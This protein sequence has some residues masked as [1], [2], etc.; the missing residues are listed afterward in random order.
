[1]V[2]QGDRRDIPHPA[3][4]D[5]AFPILGRFQCVG[6]LQLPGR[7]R[8]GAE[9]FLHEVQRLGLLE[10]TRN[11]QDDIVR[12]VKLLVEGP[13][14]FHRNLL[15]VTPVADRGLAVVVP[16]VCGGGQPLAK[17]PGRGIFTALKL[18]ADDG[19]LR[20]QILLLDEAVHE[21]VGLEIKGEFQIFI[22]RHQRLVIIHPVA[23]RASVELGAML[24]KR[25]GNVRMPGCSLEDHVLQQVRHAGLAIPLLPGAHQH[26]HVHRHLGLRLVR[27]QQ[28]PQTVVELVF[29]DPLHRSDFAG[30]LRTMAEL[31]Q[32]GKGHSNGQT[33]KLHDPRFGPQPAKFKPFPNFVR[34]GIVRAKNRNRR[35]GES[36]PLA[37]VPL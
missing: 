3:Q 19:H 13:E 18:V 25:L 36:K 22:G 9:I 4:G 26:R 31:K 6:G 7:A 30:W 29:S 27:H 14:V 5:G 2:G 10:P 37:P 8:E 24:L 33:G 15:N 11:H 23:G 20:L 34:Q 28:G 12:L 1:M 32:H 21:P 35:G 16:V 17:H